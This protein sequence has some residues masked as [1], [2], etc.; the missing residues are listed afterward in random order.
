MVAVP[1][2]GTPFRSEHSFSFEHKTPFA[3]AVSVVTRGKHCA[4]ASDTLCCLLLCYARSDGG[5]GETAYRAAFTDWKLD[6]GR[7]PYGI[8]QVHRHTPEQSLRWCWAPALVLAV[9]AMVLRA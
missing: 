9:G 1:L 3:C 7:V 6:G 2:Q 8:F 5:D 4:D